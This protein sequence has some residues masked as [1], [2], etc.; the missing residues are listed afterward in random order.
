MSKSVAIVTGAGQGVG[1]A[2]RCASRATSPRWSWSRVTAPICIEQ[3]NVDQAL[4]VFGQIDALF[5]IAGTPPG[6]ER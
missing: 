1:R 3:A 6:S 4:A 5:N 2:T